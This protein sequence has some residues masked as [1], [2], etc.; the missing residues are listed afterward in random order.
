MQI[1]NNIDNPG[2]Q[3]FI[4]KNKKERTVAIEHTLISALNCGGWLCMATG[5]PAGVFLLAAAS[6]LQLH[7]LKA[8]YAPNLFSFKSTKLKPAKTSNSSFKISDDD[9]NDFEPF[10]PGNKK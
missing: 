5:N 3:T 9:D 4:D 6:V 1:Q 7:R 2:L 10:I 8:E